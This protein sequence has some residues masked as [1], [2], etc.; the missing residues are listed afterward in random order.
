LL[1]RRTK[2]LPV[3][4]V[5]ISAGL[6]QVHGCAA[7]N[8]L[9]DI[10]NSQL[11]IDVV[12]LAIISTVSRHYWKLLPKLIIMDLAA[13][14]HLSQPIVTK[15]RLLSLPSEIK[16][17]IYQELFH[18][19]E[20][21][22]FD[23][24]STAPTTCSTLSTICTVCRT[25]LVEAKPIFLRTVNVTTL[26]DSLESTKLN[27]LSVDDFW[28]IR[29]LLIIVTKEHS[30]DYSGLPHFLPNIE[31]LTIDLTPWCPAYLDIEE[32]MKSKD[33]IVITDSDAEY[34]ED[35]RIG[36]NRL[37]ATFE[38][39]VRDLAIDRAS[40]NS[41]SKFKLL[42]RLDFVNKPDDGDDDAQTT[43]VVGAQVEQY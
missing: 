36:V 24:S 41:T 38:D 13:E 5:L 43:I 11:S 20:V 29:N 33:T 27:R 15:S 16:I 8:C 32:A 4:L 12:S 22:L 7:T 39:W 21:Q 14:G 2:V 9:G 30:R 34:D 18:G 25:F 31:Q 1:E 23:L 10:I 3:G 35:K 26:A 37:F 6:I 17:Q 40:V 19:L 42:V 28:A